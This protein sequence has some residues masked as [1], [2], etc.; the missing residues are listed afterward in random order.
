MVIHRLLQRRSIFLNKTFFA[1]DLFIGNDMT[2]VITC[3]QLLDILPL[4]GFFLPSLLLVFFLQV[5]PVCLVTNSVTLS[6]NVWGILNHQTII[7]SKSAIFN[8][9][10][11]TSEGRH[12]LPRRHDSKNNWENKTSVTMVSLQCSPY[13]LCTCKIILFLFNFGRQRL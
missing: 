9:L 4:D 13:G 7:S 11:K 3:S 2:V 12:I 8:I 1:D 5:G 10:K 6:G